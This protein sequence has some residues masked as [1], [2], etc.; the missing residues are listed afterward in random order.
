MKKVVLEQ[1]SL[2]FKSKK[3]LSQSVEIS[4]CVIS[5]WKLIQSSEK[6]RRFLLLWSKAGR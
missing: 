4:L 6:L 5:F 1:I 2:L 3:H